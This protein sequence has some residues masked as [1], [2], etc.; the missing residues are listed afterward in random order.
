LILDLNESQKESEMNCLNEPQES[1]G[2]NSR[3]RTSAPTS[4]ST[5]SRCNNQK[6]AKVDVL[7]GL[8]VFQFGK[9]SLSEGLDENKE[10][11][12]INFKS[13][14]NKSNNSIAF[15]KKLTITDTEKAMDGAPQGEIFD[16]AVVLDE[17]ISPS[18]DPKQELS[19]AV[20]HLGCASASWAEKHR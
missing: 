2:Q 1:C 6:V 12:A 17:N 5:P 15:T 18:E 10:N 7:G 11:V 20:M 16:V 13:S 19:L 4:P 3:K 8:S 14:Y 9:T